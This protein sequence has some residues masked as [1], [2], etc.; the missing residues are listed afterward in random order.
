MNRKS[1]NIAVP[2]MARQGKVQEGSTERRIPSGKSL[3]LSHIASAITGHKLLLLM[4]TA[5]SLACLALPSPAAEMQT[6]SFADKY[7]SQFDSRADTSA[8]VKHSR[9]VVFDATSSQEQH[10]KLSLMNRVLSQISSYRLGSASYQD[11]E[12]KLDGFAARILLDTNNA[13]GIV[14]AHLVLNT[15]N[16]LRIGLGRVSFNA[17]DKAREYYSAQ[18]EYLFKQQ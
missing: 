12:I 6:Y 1:N 2:T 3:G 17:P 8:L 18:L 11:A 10:S 13:D 14:G 16:N 15:K 9:P 7:H 5:A 4:I